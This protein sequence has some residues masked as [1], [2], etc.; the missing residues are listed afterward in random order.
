M[1]ARCLQTLATTQIDSLAFHKAIQ[2]Y[3]N[4]ALQPIVAPESQAEDLM[5]LLHDSEMLRSEDR[6]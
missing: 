6:G 3:F 1:F 5:A 2:G 4:A